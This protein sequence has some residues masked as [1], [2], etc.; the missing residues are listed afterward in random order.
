VAIGA[1]ELALFQLFEHECTR[2]TTDQ[3]AD[4]LD[5]LETG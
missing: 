2:E 1:H 3:N 4:R 5:L